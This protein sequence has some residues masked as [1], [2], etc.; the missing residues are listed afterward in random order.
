MAGQ[1][2]IRFHKGQNHGM[3]VARYHQLPLMTAHDPTAN[4]HI[5]WKSLLLLRSPR[6]AWSGM[7]QF[8][9]HGNHPGKSSVII[10][11]NN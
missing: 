6:P 4:L 11:A 10:F 3:P 8:V 7:M 1:I 9:H 2:L 5:L